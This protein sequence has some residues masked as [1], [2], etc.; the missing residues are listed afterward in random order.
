MAYCGLRQHRMGGDL[1]ADNRRQIVEDRT[2]YYRLFLRMEIERWFDILLF[3]QGVEIHGQAI[4]Q[5]LPF[6]L[7]DLRH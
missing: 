7:L 2:R 3:A 4:H 6:A 5:A 1:F